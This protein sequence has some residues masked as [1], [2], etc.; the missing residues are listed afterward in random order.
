MKK[1][2]IGLV[3]TSCCWSFI[4]CNSPAPGKYFDIAILNCNLM[5][6]FA[7]TGL[8]R[9]LESPSVKMIDGNK[10]NFAPMKRKEIID[11]KIQMLEAIREKL[12]SLK[13]TG[14]TRDILRTSSA[15]Y[16]YVLPVYKNEYMELARL[17]DENAPKESID[18]FTQSISDKYYTGY[19]QLFQK[20][21]LAGKSFAIKHDIKVNWD[22]QTSP[23]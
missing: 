12:K 2:V 10:D 23:R 14:D 19:E 4:A 8:Q 17:Y 22:V 9:E 7:G 6:G 15:L 20:L 5:H 21:T 1:F 18:A 16:D 3:L 11:D 13:E